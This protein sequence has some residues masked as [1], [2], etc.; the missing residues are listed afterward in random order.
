MGT[1]VS[2]AGS[3]NVNLDVQV[4]GHHSGTTVVGGIG[5]SITI[6]SR[7]GD[8]ATV[9]AG[10]GNDSIA[11]DSRHGSITVGSGNDQLKLTGSGNIFE[12]GAGGND[13]INL[14]H[15]SDTI[16]EAGHA[17]IYGS[18]GSAK[19]Q[20]ATVEFKQHVG[21]G[22][23]HDHKHHHGYSQGSGWDNGNPYHEVDVLS[24]NA[25]L[26]GG[27]HCTIFV[28]GTGNVDMFGGKGN[29]TF[30]G[31]SGHTWMTGGSTHNVFAFTH[32]GIGGQDV[33][34]NFTSG[35]DKLYLEGHSLCWLESHGDVT[36]K[37]GNTWIT[38]DGGKTH[39]E[40]KG[41]TGLTSHDITT[42]K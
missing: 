34:T 8:G 25:T 33:I 15:G 2:I 18:F 41:F 32:S 36:T 42:H 22:A 27:D 13:T 5:D 11:I 30:I 40:L 20:G 28:G 14:G 31:G 12:H 37:G 23:D 16:T 26:V 9:V 17:T 6:D 29:D 39:I 1:Y 35:H 4:Y 19:I 21:S 38:L 7:H 10:N 24:G 3:G